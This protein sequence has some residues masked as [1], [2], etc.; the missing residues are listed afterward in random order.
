MDKQL[1]HGLD[2][3]SGAT[4]D[5]RG[6]VTGLGAL[7]MAAALGAGALGVRGAFA[8]Q[9]S[10]GADGKAQAGSAAA[11]ASADASGPIEIV[12]QLGKTITFDEVP[13]RMATCIIPLP[14]IFFAVMGDT[15]TMVGCNPASMPAYEK[16]T[17]K[18]MYPSMAN[19]NTDWC[20]RD[21]TVNVEELLK[22]EPDVVFQWTTQ[23]EQIEK[24][25]EAGLKVIALKYG[26]VDDLKTWVD[27]LGRLFRREERAEFLK[28]YFDEQIA[29]VTE[30]TDELTDDQRP[31]AIHL[32][33]DLTVNG[34][35]FTPYWM[36]KSGANDPAATLDSQSVKVD[37]EQILAWN[38]EYVFIG[39]FTEIMPSDLM[40]NRFDGEDWSLVKAVQEGN[41]Y[42]IPI[43][44][45]R[46]DPPCVE[47]P[48]MVKW[49]ATTMHPD[50]FLDMAMEDEV[51]RFY[52]DV[53][54]YQLSDEEVESILGHCQD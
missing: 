31:V 24:M 4:C 5:R 6:F 10:A 20:A 18:A 51:K 12:D 3:R 22:L 1:D 46:W 44:G 43:G 53:Y 26:T 21:F 32:S 11:D 13:K 27:L 45:Y 2:P 25:E 19:V 33:E 40:E 16:S 34:T 23:P 35:G 41:V 39:N 8:S 30:V 17:L 37:M 52:E 28:Q 15:D 49:L 47:T 54:D 29:E 38:P 9:G 7:A 42:K 36:E 50:L 48:L 14:S